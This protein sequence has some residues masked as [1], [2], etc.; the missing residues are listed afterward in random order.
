T[1]SRCWWARMACRPTVVARAAGGSS[2][3][4]GSTWRAAQPSRSSA[5]RSTR[6]SRDGK[7]LAYLKLSEDGYTMSLDIAAPDGSGTRELIGGTDFQGF[8]APRFT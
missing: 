7:Q 5:T 6:L 3:W 1:A 2:R 8:Y 4:C